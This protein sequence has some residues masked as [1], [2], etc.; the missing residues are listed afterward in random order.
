MYHPLPLSTGRSTAL[1]VMDAWQAY[2]DAHG[3]ETI[4]VSGGETDVCVLATVLAAIDIGYRVIIAEDA[5]CSSSDQ[6]HD[7]LLQ[8]YAERYSIQIKVASTTDILRVWAVD[9]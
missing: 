1:S 9:R 7:A 4:I 5:P 2:L 8:L 6:S 3:V